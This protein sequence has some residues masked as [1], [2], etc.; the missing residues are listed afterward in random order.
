MLDA[1]RAKARRGELRIGVPSCGPT[2]IGPI[3]EDC[4]F[5]TRPL[6]ARRYFFDATCDEFAAG[7]EER[8]VRDIDALPPGVTASIVGSASSEGGWMRMKRVVR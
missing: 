5:V 4:V 2:E 3:P 6:G 1:A 8:L 7:E